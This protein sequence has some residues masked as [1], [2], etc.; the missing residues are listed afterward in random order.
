ML[1]K[2]KQKNQ[3]NN[4]DLSHASRLDS[5]KQKEIE[6]GLQ[7]IYGHGD[8]DFT[9]IEKAQSRLTSVLFASVLILGFIAITAWSGFFLY[10]KFFEQKHDELFSL[11]VDVDPEIKSGQKTDIVIHYEN[12][13]TVPIASLEIEVNV[14]SGFILE[15]SSSEP[16]DKSN[17]I[18]KIGE[19]A[20][21]ASNDITLSGTWITA[22]PSEN[23]VQAFARF[24]PANF[25]ADFEDIAVSYVTTLQSV[26]TTTITGTNEVSPGQTASYNIAVENT[27]DQARENVEIIATLPNGFYMSESEPALAAGSATIWKFEKIEAHEIKTVAFSGSYAADAQGFEYIDVK[28]TTLIDNRSATQATSQF[29]TDVLASDFSLQLVSAGSTEKSAVDVGGTLRLS[30]AYENTADYPIESASLLL[31]FQSDNSIPIKWSEASLSG[32]TLT[33]DGIVWKSA[34]LGAI[35]PGQKEV[36]NL[37]FPLDNELG[38]GDADT[39]TVSAIATT[40]YGTVRSSQIN[41]Y[42]NTQAEL[43]ASVHYYDDSGAILGN[44]PIP[45]QKGKTTTYRLFFTINNSLHDLT[46]IRITATLPPNVTWLNQTSTELG[47]I[48]FDDSTN[49]ITWNLSSL[50]TSVSK[51]SANVAVSITPTDNDID[52]FIKLL[53]TSSLTATD[54]VSN[55]TIS[56]AADSLTTDLID[57]QFAAGGGV[58]IE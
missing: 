42:I 13:T 56:R 50:S 27:S 55:E 5:K 54:S 45:P 39:F 17:L 49:I 36:L 4:S 33:K 52:S 14:P 9:K 10:S 47:D 12:P 48:T 51:V 25:N 21:L 19:L 37:S 23:P 2:H 53:S 18:W 44:G 11:S 34:S 30:I 15:S 43:L 38:V 40:E 26:I 8:V 22:V 28:I 46:D 31:D 24:R 35:E 1:K 57:D 29:Y 3:L 41:V 20:G 32:G 7:A 6:E 58:V 16:T